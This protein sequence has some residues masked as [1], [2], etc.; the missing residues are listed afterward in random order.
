MGVP[1][2]TL[3]GD[4]LIAR[5]GESMMRCVGL[6]EWVAYSQA[7]YVRIAVDM[8]ADTATLTQLRLRLRDLARQS[9][10]YDAV[11]FAHHLTLALRAMALKHRVV[12]DD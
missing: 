4:T 11:L 9:P 12:G 5:Q 10:L 3:S 6:S 7:D 2:I 8:A 1:T